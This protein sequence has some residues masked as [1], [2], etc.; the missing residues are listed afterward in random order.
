MQ[1][2]SVCAFYY[3]R[4]GESTICY[5]HKVTSVKQVVQILDNL[6]KY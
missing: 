3:T 5:S 6:E 4:Y 2:P 1:Q